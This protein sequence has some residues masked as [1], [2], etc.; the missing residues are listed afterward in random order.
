[1]L[2]TIRR[3]LTPSSNQAEDRERSLANMSTDNSLAAPTL[4][5]RDS[6]PPP[7]S[8]ISPIESPAPENLPFTTPVTNGDDLIMTEQHDI[9][10]DLSSDQDSPDREQ[11]ATDD[12]L[13][14]PVRPSSP[15]T[16]SH[17]GVSSLDGASDDHLHIPEDDAQPQSSPLPSTEPA[18]STSKP[19]RAPTPGANHE[20]NSR[21][22]RT[23]QTPNMETKAKGKTLR[24]EKPERGGS[25]SVAASVE[26]EQSA[27]AGID[28]AKTLTSSKARAPKR[29]R[30]DDPSEMESK[31]VKK[32]RGQPKKERGST[33]TVKQP[34]AMDHEPPKK[35]GRPKKEGFTATVK[36]Q[37]SNEQDSPKKRGRPKKEEESEQKVK[38]QRT[39]KEDAPAKRGGPSKNVLP[40]SRHTTTQTAR[41]S[42]RTKA[43]A[44]STDQDSTAKETPKKRG[45]PGKDAEPTKADEPT[46][47]P[48][49][50]TPKKRGRPKKVEEA[51]QD[52][53]PQVA[54]P[55][56]RGK[57]KTKEEIADAAAGPQG[58]K[59]RGRPKATKG[60]D[61]AS[62]PKTPGKRGRPKKEPA[63]PKGAK[64]VGVVKKKAG[65]KAG[66]K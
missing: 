55:S 44:A 53:E 19:Q 60:E 35:R 25:K 4:L 65:R 64:P 47:V 5:F 9:P 18:Q 17:H 8:P 39:S 57:P 56:K 7:F 62:K 23:P 29:K 51:G 31:H 38:T 14:G 6:S 40:T 36:Q 52:T 12:S 20:L 27:P 22:S 10:M 33:A 2:S 45:R 1:M 41:E 61:D 46:S 34:G 21:T 37:A 54:S 63:A 13:L 28:D 42:E 3:A 26:P 58:P 30:D 24:L 48:A 11:E 15:V 16:E 49:V 59:T 43:A 50:D 66:R 32:Q